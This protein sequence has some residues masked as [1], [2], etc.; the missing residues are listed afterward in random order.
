MGRD[1]E[2]SGGRECPKG[3]GDT[4]TWDIHRQAKKTND[5]VGE[6]DTYL[7]GLQYGYRLQGIGEAP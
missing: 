6:V 7:W 1:L 3:S 2:Q 4:D 5:G